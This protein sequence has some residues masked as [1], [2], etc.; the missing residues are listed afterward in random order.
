[1]RISKIQLRQIVQEE[2]AQVFEGYDP[3]GYD[4]D[5]GGWRE[6]P[7]P[8]EDSAEFDA[9][10]AKR[11]R[12][13]PGRAIDVHADAEK[14]RA[15]ASHDPQ[16][17]LSSEFVED[18]GASAVDWA[19][20]VV[21]NSDADLLVLGA[22]ETG[23]GL[24]DIDQARTVRNN[25]MKVIG[26]TA[27]E[28]ADNPMTLAR[29]TGGVGKKALPGLARDLGIRAGMRGFV[30][31][32]IG[33]IIGELGTKGIIAAIYAKQDGTSF[34][35]GWEKQSNIENLPIAW[36]E[37]WLTNPDMTAD[38]AVNM[39][40]ALNKMGR[41]KNPWTA[42]Q[43]HAFYNIQM[44]KNDYLGNEERMAALRLGDSGEHPGF[45]A[46]KYMDPPEGFEGELKDWRAKAGTWELSPYGEWRETKLQ[47]EI[48]K[49]L[50][51]SISNTRYYL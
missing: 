4:L 39:Q 20:R 25:A 34:A 3:V 6:R 17:G 43:A 26:Q 38:Q 41:E 28:L 16:F 22:I 13:Y 18:F 10:V 33:G 37:G 45:Y 50:N 19:G 51:S 30:G 7:D 24:H 47:E 27:D 11:A 31:G 42:Q 23:M 35:E 40:V 8:L 46:Y 9:A 44:N 15:Q 12:E 5:T 36:F 48:D 21:P 32:G 49:T 14:K 2:L 1:M 29:R